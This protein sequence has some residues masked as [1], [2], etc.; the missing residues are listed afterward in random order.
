MTFRKNLFVLLSSVFLAVIGAMLM[1]IDM[2]T[3]VDG[4][5]LVIPTVAMALL[6]E[7]LWR[8]LLNDR[9]KL[10]WQYFLGEVF[11]IGSGLSWFWA[12]QA[13]T[14]KEVIIRLSV[15]FLLGV[16]G[17]VWFALCYHP[18]V[19]S[20]EEREQEKWA[21]YRRKI[22]AGTK[23]DAFKTLAGLLRYRLLGDTLSGDLDFTRPLA[24]YADQ[25][26]TYDEVLGAD[27]DQ[28]GT[29]G[30]VRDAAHEYL[31]ALTRDLP[32]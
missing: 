4:L 13:A 20:T 22:E 25:F 23:A 16:L 1:R 12:A 32:E 11:V 30:A 2:M 29:L 15:V 6:I 31:Q 7:D 8:K 3:I 10:T 18:S 14:L 17:G 9:E 19:Q 21:K 24:V 5:T 26:M 28:T 27:D